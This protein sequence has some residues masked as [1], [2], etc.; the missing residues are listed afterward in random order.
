MEIALTGLARTAFKKIDYL[1]VASVVSE[2]LGTVVICSCPVSQ[3]TQAHNL[4]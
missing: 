4:R 1:L 3:E 2:K